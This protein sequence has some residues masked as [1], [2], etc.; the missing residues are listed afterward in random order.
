MVEPKKTEA[1]CA[2]PNK[3]PIKEQENNQD[4]LAKDVKCPKS[5]VPDKFEIPPMPEDYYDKVPK[6]QLELINGIK[7]KELNAASEKKEDET[8]VAADAY[9][10]AMDVHAKAVR[11]KDIAIKSLE[12]KSKNKKI[13]LLRVFKEKLIGLLPKGCAITGKDT[14][15]EGP[16]IEERVPSDK[17]ATNIAE[18]NKLLADED[19][20]YQKK[21]KDI[22][23]KYADAKIALEKAEITFNSAICEAIL[24]EVLASKQADVVWRASVSK[25]VEQ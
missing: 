19:I 12:T 21:L 23:L 17:L 24:T 4:I 13:E 7:T 6:E 1:G 3:E 8:A 25:L 18:L 22:N 5:P 20:D 15:K 10:T 9:Q 11:D 2:E 14:D 16:S